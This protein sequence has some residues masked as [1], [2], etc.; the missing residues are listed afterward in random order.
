MAGGGGDVGGA[1]HGGDDRYPLGT[2]LHHFCC[3]LFIY[4]TDGYH[5]EVDSLND[6]PQPFQAGGGWGIGLG[7]GG[8]DGRRGLYPGRLMMQ[9]H[10]CANIDDTRTEIDR[11]DQHIVARIGERAGYVE[12]AARFKTNAADV[13][14][15]ERLEAML[16]QRRAWAEKYGLDPDMIEKLY[17][18]MVNHFIQQEMTHWKQ[19]Q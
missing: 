13:R 11:I 16:R 17:R 3:I 15:A 8:E 2:S 12:A 19:E 10:E 1:D 6:S 14:A 18:D 5:W 9:P 7:G 4:P